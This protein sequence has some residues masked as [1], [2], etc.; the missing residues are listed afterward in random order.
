MEKRLAVVIVA[1]ACLGLP[2]LARAQAS[3]TGAQPAAP[4][5]GKT[6]KPTSERE[7]ELLRKDIRSQKKQLIAE[8]LP[9][10]DAEATKF[11]PIYEQYTAELTKINDKKLAVIR[12]YANQY[13]SLTDEKALSLDKQWQELDI[14]AGQL[15]EKYIP[16]VAKAIGGKKAAAFGQIDRRIALLVELQLASELPLVHKQ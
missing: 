9:L 16:I 2:A 13:G 7:V 12:D 8:N 11:W 1:S 3:G 15:R 10:T 5:Q 4:S 6:A 14:E